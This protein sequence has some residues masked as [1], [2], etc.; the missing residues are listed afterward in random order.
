MLNR[1]ARVEGKDRVQMVLHVPVELIDL[2][3]VLAAANNQA[4]IG[5]RLS[6]RAQPRNRAADGRRATS[7]ARCL[8]FASL[9]MTD[10][11]HRQTAY[12]HGRNA[13]EG[14]SCSEPG[15]S[16]EPCAGRCGDY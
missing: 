6:F 16:R 1:Q 9:D 14:R 13:M 8:D 10:V 12:H 4:D 5:G 11:L 3:A 7:A 2:I 15:E